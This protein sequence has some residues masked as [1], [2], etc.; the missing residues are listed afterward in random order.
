ME[1]KSIQTRAWNSLIKGLFLIALLFLLLVLLLP[2]NIFFISSF[3]FIGAIVL[4]TWMVY[5]AKAIP[6]CNNCGY[7]VFSIF[8]INNV[9]VIVK[10]IVGKH[11]SNCGAT[12]K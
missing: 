9:P 2:D 5:L 6:R 11:C 8:E 12:L 3:Y 10:S 4:I 1:E 7:G